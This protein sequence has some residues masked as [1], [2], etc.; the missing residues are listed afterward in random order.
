MFTW[1]HRCHQLTGTRLNHRENAPSL[2]SDIPPTPAPLPEPR[3][4]GCRDGVLGRKIGA[5]P[6]Q[7]ATTTPKA[8]ASPVVRQPPT[9]AELAA[10]IDRG[11][12]FL[13]KSQNSNG[14][15]STSEQPAVTALVLTAFNREPTRR[16]RSNRPSELRQAYD[17]ILGSAKP[18]G[19]IHRGTFINYNSSLSLLALAT[20]DETTFLP[21]IRAARGYI[22]GSQID[23]GAG[24]KADTEFDGGV[25]YGSKYQHSDLNNTLMA[26]EA[27]RWSEHVLPS[28]DGPLTAPVNLMASRF[29]ASTA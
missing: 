13:L 2:R 11:L 27:M 16:F 19:S 29:S 26:L 6:G 3:D 17:F 28:K 25:G 22:A 8:G 15:W 9:R 20:A 1:T 4:G 23:F 21:V 18:D 14:W 24:G 5:G 7:N 10:A 12:T